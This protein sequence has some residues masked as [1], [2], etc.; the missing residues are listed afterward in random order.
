MPLWI[1]LAALIF[2]AYGLGLALGWLAFR[3]R[4]RRRPPR[5]GA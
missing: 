2:A 1:E 5:K 3:R 4:R